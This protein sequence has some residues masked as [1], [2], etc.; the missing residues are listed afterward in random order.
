MYQSKIDESDKNI[1]TSLKN[2]KGVCR[3]LFSTI[4]FGM[5]VDIPNIRTVIHCGPSS[6]TDDYVQEAGR[7]G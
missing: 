7:A 4:A 3:V 2:E 5:G 1:L 6:D